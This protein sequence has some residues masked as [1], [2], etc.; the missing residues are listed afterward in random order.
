MHTESESLAS[1]LFRRWQALSLNDSL[2]QVTLKA[3]QRLR[4]ALL[5]PP[6]RRSARGLAARFDE[7]RAAHGVELLVSP[8][9]L[10]D[11]SVDHLQARDLAIAD[12]CG[13]PSG[14]QVQERLVSRHLDTEV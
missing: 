4:R 13:Q 10:L 14:R 9:E 11:E 2:E 5:P 7:A 1:Q 8:H 12:H 6:L 3:V